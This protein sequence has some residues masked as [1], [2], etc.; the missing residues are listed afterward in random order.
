MDSSFAS[1]TATLLTLRDGRKLTAVQLQLAYAELAA[2]YLQDRWGNDV[3]PVTAEVM[4][5]WLSVLDR[6]E[7]DPMTCAGELDWVAK[8]RVLESYRSR[9]GL[10]WD[11]PTLALIDLQYSD[12]RPEKGLYHRLARAGRIARL[13][14]DA[15]V[16]QAVDEPPKDTRAYFRGRCLRDYPDRIAAASWDSVI[17]DLPGHGSLQRIPTLD[18]LRGTEAHVGALMDRCAG[19]EQLFAALTD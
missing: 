2:K 7:R 13:T 17:F 10:D 4:T 18:P 1:A 9:D 5:R 14:T 15:E 16:L 3:D 11:S 12:L 8:L 19:A 6:L